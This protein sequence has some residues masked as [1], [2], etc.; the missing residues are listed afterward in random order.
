ML[1]LSV[2]RRPGCQSGSARCRYPHRHSRPRC[3]HQGNLHNRRHWIIRESDARLRERCRGH[4]QIQC[5]QCCLWKVVGT[6]GVPDNIE[7]V[8][9][10][11]ACYESDHWE[12]DLEGA[13]AG[14]GLQCLLM[15][16][17]PVTL[18]LLLATWLVFFIL[19]FLNNSIRCF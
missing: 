13:A 7:V 8:T 14:R 6:E 12:G 18:N 1:T 16:L 5:D 2:C 17:S 3:T 4:V 11:V 9:G 10:L 15:D 19:F